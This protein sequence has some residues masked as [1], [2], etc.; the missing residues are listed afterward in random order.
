M[1]FQHE[2]MTETELYKILHW[3]SRK[4]LR[5]RYKLGCEDSCEGRNQGFPEGK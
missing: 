5:K 3:A 4:N 2:E 1:I